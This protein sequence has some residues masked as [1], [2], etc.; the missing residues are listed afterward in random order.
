MDVEHRAELVDR[1]IREQSGM[2]AL[3]ITAS[4]RPKDSSA[5]STI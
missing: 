2:P 5:M 3:L 1:Q 4:M